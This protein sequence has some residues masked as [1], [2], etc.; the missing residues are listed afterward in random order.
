M[1][2][3]R[4]TKTTVKKSSETKHARDSKSTKISTSP[5]PKAKKTPD[6]GPM[7]GK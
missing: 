3:E 2:T 7:K 6:P 1:A 4:N 5:H